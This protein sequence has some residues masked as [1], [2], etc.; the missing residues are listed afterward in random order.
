MK[1]N[2]DKQA[3]RVCRLLLNGS[4]NGHIS[5]TVP[6]CACILGEAK[7]NWGTSTG[8]GPPLPPLL[9]LLMQVRGSLVAVFGL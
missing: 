2:L 9:V 4:R 5:H 3:P 7:P 1:Y 8:P 6:L